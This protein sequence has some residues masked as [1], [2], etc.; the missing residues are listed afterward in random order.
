VAN[1][2][3]YVP[4]DLHAQLKRHDI[5]VSQACQAAL[6]RKVRVAERGDLKQA[7]RNPRT[8][9]QTAADRSA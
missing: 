7:S 3:I 2:N 5:N 1:V 6:R 4:A 9:T 8:A